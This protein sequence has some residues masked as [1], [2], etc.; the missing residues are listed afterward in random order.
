[1]FFQSSSICIIY[2]LEFFSIAPLLVNGL[3]FPGTT[4]PFSRISNIYDYIVIGMRLDETVD[5]ELSLNQNV[6]NRL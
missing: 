3:N 6:T 1:M 5:E 2:A 4:R